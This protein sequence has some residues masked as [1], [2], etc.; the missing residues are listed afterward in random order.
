MRPA[1]FRK[2]DRWNVVT[3]GKDDW[4]DFAADLKSRGKDAQRQ[5]LD[6]RVARELEAEG[7]E[8]QPVAPYLIVVNKRIR[9]L[10]R[11]NGCW[12]ACALSVAEFRGRGSRARSAGDVHTLLPEFLVGLNDR[13]RR[14]FGRGRGRL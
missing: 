9:R 5:L 11:T 2:H 12:R 1:G 10:H 7:L 3:E 8:Y 14:R 4:A 6:P 13:S